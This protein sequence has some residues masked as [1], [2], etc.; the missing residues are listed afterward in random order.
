M[1]VC[2][3]GFS[4]LEVLI[5]L[6]LMALFV[7]IAIPSFRSLTKVQLRT[8]ANQMAGMIRDVYNKAAI[9]N[10]TFRLVFDLDKS[11]YWVEVSND[12]VHLPNADD[13]F[14][15]GKLNLFGDEETPKKY[16]QPPSF[17]PEDEEDFVKEK[18]PKDIKFFGFWADNMSERIKEGQAALYFFPGGYTQKAQISLTDDDEGKHIL[19]VV[20]EPLTGEVK[21]EDGEPEIDKE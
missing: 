9:S 12:E 2:K 6:L 7:A 4:L 14:E 13:N 19:T 15:G 1:Y 10:K 3:K 20:T 5:V 17:V 11:E 21:I 16:A 18:L 8:S